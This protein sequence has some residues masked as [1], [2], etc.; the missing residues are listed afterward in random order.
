MRFNI[1]DLCCCGGMGADG[2]AAVFGASALIGYDIEDQPHYPYRFVRADV[3]RL[4]ERSGDHLTN[5]LHLYDALHTSF[6]CQLFTTG[7]HLR[8][9]QGGK[10]KALDLLTPGLGLLRTRWNHKPWI[11]ENVE[12]NQGKVRAIMAPRE[13]ESLILLCGSMFG[14]QVQRHR[15]FLANF[16][17][18]TPPPV[19]KPP[20]VKGK[21]GKYRDQGCDHSLFPAD[22]VTGNPRPWGVWHV[23]GDSIPSGGRTARD[24][25][26]ARQVMGGHRSLPWETI[27]EGFPPAYTSWIA[28]DLLRHLL[29]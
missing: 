22:P 24:A 4:L 12:D 2:Y 16:P 17:L 20:H 27:K 13:G 14:L 8:T 6:P 3:M 7:G 5:P 26:H 25:E 10:T 9:A 23:P 21:A 15:L 1:G 11:V 28:A 18:R 19:A 29:R